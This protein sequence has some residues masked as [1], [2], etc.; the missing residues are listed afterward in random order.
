MITRIPIFCC[1]LNTYI[2]SLIFTHYC[3]VAENGI[4]EARSEE[5]TSELQ[6]L[7]YLVCRLLL[8]KKN[9]VLQAEYMDKDPIK[10]VM[11]EASN[12]HLTAG[13]AFNGIGFWLTTSAAELNHPL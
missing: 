13:W 7:A 6:S 12:S 2:S 4:I 11:G 8:E 3:L 10:H 9:I 5:H 1:L